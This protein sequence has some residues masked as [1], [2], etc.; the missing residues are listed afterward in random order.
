MKKS[1]QQLILLSLAISMLA[2]CQGKNP[3]DRSNDPTKKYSNLNQS[4]S[5]YKQ[6]ENPALESYKVKVAQEEQVLQDRIT[7]LTYE[8]E[9]LLAEK[10][11]TQSACGKVYDMEIEG[12]EGGRL[13]FIENEERT[14][15][16]NV[17]SYLADDFEL[18]VDSAPDNSVKLIPTNNKNL[19][20]LTWKPSSGLIHEKES[21]YKGKISI[22][23]I[24]KS[25][26]TKASECLNVNLKEDRGVTVAL[27]KTQP[28]LTMNALAQTT[29]PSHQGQFLAQLT[30]KD[31]SSS[32]NRP[33][34]MIVPTLD[35][36]SKIKDL[37]YQCANPKATGTEQT[38]SVDCVVSLNALKDQITKAKNGDL[39]EARV[40]FSAISQGSAFKTTPVI[41]LVKVVVDE[42]SK[43][44]SEEPVKGDQ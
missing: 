38:W 26:S 29:I 33:P 9:S 4:E 21:F 32:K 22:S 34:V 5:S 11:S 35:E 41:E 8:K 6:L 13:D 15:K 36:S 43:V 2:A 40:H 28:I 42:A 14:L 12:S 24:P 25:S 39:I 10:A 27:N 3:A 44:Q 19:W 20:T 17:R 18:R 7:Q 37:N 30:I 1:A 31:A 16:V 23:F